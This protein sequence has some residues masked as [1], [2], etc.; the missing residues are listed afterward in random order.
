MISYDLGIELTNIINF[1]SGNQ[2]AFQ[3]V[4]DSLY[5]GLCLFTNRFTF[6][7]SAAE[8]VVQEAFVALWN[9]HANMESEVHIKSFLYRTCRNIALNYLKHQ[10]IENNYSQT[11]AC[12]SESDF[13]YFVLE[14][15]VNRIILQTETELPKRCKEIFILAMQGKSNEEIAEQLQVSVNTVKTQKKIAY[16]QLKRHI[17][18]I[19]LLAAFCSTIS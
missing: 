16:R 13:V 10:R 14:E 11:S 9:N 3:S 17:S 4:F 19:T 12:E 15:E 8:D 1:R 5:D 2:K 7:M 6:D 18:N